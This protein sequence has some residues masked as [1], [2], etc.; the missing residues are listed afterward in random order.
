MRLGS[1]AGQIDPMP[2]LQAQTNEPAGQFFQRPIGA[3]ENAAIACDGAV[4]TP[5]LSLRSRRCK[6]GLDEEAPPQIAAACVQDIWPRAGRTHRTSEQGAGE[7]PSCRHV[8]ILA[9]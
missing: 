2:G 1:L 4:G 8:L 9:V 7:R 5:P 3:Q 6:G